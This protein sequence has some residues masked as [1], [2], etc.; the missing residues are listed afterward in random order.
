MSLPSPI[1]AVVG[2]DGSGK[3]TLTS[4]L[5]AWLSESRPTVIC[6][7]GKQS[8]NIGRALGRLPLLGSKLEGSI[9]KKTKAARTE[10]GPSLAVAIGIYAFT[11]RRTRRFRRMMKL[12][13]A[14]N[15]IITDRFPQIEVP[16]RMDGPGLDH[17]RSDGII[18]WLSRRERQHFAEMVAHLPDL[19]IRLNVS[20]DVAKARKPDHRPSALAYK[21]DALS[22]VSFQGAP[23]VEVNADEPLEAVEAKAKAAIAQLFQS[24]YGLII[25]SSSAPQ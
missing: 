5:A 3:S 18:G 17:A 19:V 16:G 2:C 8:G 12:F 24:R 10:A 22:R 20:L 7:L 9:E 15:T 4:I 21:I 14:G 25:P 1:I 6:H 11:V 13:R 23:I